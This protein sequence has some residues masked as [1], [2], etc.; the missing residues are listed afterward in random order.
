MSFPPSLNLFGEI[1]LLVSLIIWLDFLYIF[2]FIIL[3]L[4]FLYS[5]YIYL[6][7]QY[8][9]LFFSLHYLVYINLR[10]YLLLFLH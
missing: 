4:I 5:L 9:K 1:F 6:Y 2:Y 8:G 7:S 3:I 10:E